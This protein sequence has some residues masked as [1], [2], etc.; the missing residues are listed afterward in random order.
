MLSVVRTALVW[1]LHVLAGLLLLLL[2]PRVGRI[3][4]S[5]EKKRTERIV[6][7]YFGKK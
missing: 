3:D 6:N 2:L 4:R 5:S 1:M 7:L